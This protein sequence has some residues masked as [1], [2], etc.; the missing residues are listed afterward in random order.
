MS[1]VQCCELT[2][3]ARQYGEVVL[4]DDST[5]QGPGTLARN[6]SRC[7]EGMARVF[8]VMVQIL[9]TSGVSPYK[10]D[11]SRLICPRLQDFVA[12]TGAVSRYR[13]SRSQKLVKVQD[14][15]CVQMRVPALTLRSKRHGS[16]CNNHYD[17]VLSAGAKVEELA[18]KPRFGGAKTVTNNLPILSV[19]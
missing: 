11:R 14:L 19:L 10:S 12:G 4:P 18:T 8:A 15:N 5:G 13:L 1:N 16:G 9:L 17:F 3:T 6:L 7:K 2:I